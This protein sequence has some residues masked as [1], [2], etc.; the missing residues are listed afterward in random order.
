M[1]TQG[2]WIN[3]VYGIV[4]RYEDVERSDYQRFLLME[5]FTSHNDTGASS[6]THAV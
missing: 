5:K 1:T 3:D 2:L 6:L 4:E